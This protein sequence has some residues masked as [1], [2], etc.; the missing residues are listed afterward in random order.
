MTQTTRAKKYRR[1]RRSSKN[2]SKIM[3]TYYK[4]NHVAAAQGKPV[5]WIAIVVPI[6]LLKGFDLV[7]AVPENHSAMIAA[8]KRGVLQAEAAEERGFSMDL[9]S[10]ARIDLGTYF[11]KGEGCPSKGL[12]EPDLLISNNNNCSLLVKW[13]DVYH[14]MKDVPH[15]NLDVPFCYNPQREQDL[16]YIVNQFR[17]LIEYIKDQTGQEFN[18]PRV[19]QAINYSNDALKHWKR[20]LNFATHHPS[21]IT[22]FDSFVH[23]ADRKSVV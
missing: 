1:L 14:R 19:K 13:F 12:P 6:E 2:L 9:C 17:E 23:M 4:M 11:K 10:Y 8:K 7:V 20:F 15:F 22:A 21:G 16:K 18:L 3:G 5:V